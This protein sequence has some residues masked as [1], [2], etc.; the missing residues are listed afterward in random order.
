M[1]HLLVRR[2]YCLRTWS[3]DGDV[4]GRRFWYSSWLCVHQ[5]WCRP[6]DAFFGTFQSR[7]QHWITWP[8][9]YR[10]VFTSSIVAWTTV[11]NRV[12]R[13]LSEFDLHRFHSLARDLLGSSG[14]SRLDRGSMPFVAQW[15]Y[16]SERMKDEVLSAAHGMLSGLHR[17]IQWLKRLS[18]SIVH[19]L[20]AARCSSVAQLHP[21]YMA[22]R[23]D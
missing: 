2:P 17:W 12:G 16:S 10:K 7:G 18:Q 15:P 14:C 1:L 13:L 6:S 8:S 11:L 20:S 3:V 5:S 23:L 9:H 21:S 4:Q 22:T 19:S